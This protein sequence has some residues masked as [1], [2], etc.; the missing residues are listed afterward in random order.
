MCCCDAAGGTGLLT[1]LSHLAV[2][3]QIGPLFWDGP[4]RRRA[5]HPSCCL[6]GLLPSAQGRHGAE[7][8][9]HAHMPS[10]NTARTAVQELDHQ[11]SVN[12]QFMRSRAGWCICLHLLVCPAQAH[13]NS[14]WQLRLAHNSMGPAACRRGAATHR[15]WYVRR[16][17]VQA[18]GAALGLALDGRRGP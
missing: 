18:A 11:Q 4:R 9:A 12:D 2:R 13:S 6:A 1:E 16:L 10:D 17:A 7:M 8:P 15:Q 14:L 5:V 3:V